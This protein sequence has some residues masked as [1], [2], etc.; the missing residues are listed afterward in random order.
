MSRVDKEAGLFLL[1]KLCVMH[2]CLFGLA[3]LFSVS[4]SGFPPS[5]FHERASLDA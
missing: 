4:F 2:I 1:S 3:P 5:L